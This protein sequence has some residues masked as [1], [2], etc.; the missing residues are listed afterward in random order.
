MRS[1]LIVGWHSLLYLEQSLTLLKTVAYILNG[2]ATRLAFSNGL[3][4]EQL[5]SSL[6]VDT[7]EARR[8]WWIIYIQE[9]ELSLD[10]G[11]PMCLRSSEM[12]MNYPKAQVGVFRMP[13]HHDC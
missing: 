5:H 4:I 7:Q 6:G 11:R 2:I 8:T 12:T 3:N 1:N 9:V 10:S 13:G